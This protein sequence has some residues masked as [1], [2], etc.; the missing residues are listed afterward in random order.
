[1]AA[2]LACGPGAVLSHSSAAELW[3]LV[4][5]AGAFIEVSVP[6]PRDPRCH[7]LRVHRRSVLRP[8]DKTE[9]DGIPTTS[10]V[11]T[12]ID[13]G[14]SFTLKRSLARSKRAALA[15]PRAAEGV[16]QPAPSGVAP[17]SDSRIPASPSMRAVAR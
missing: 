5:E 1:M 14:Y 11:A 8:E 3:R 12:I 13:I 10:P 7:G 6:L 4:D 2:V 15:L 16:R 9:E 17:G